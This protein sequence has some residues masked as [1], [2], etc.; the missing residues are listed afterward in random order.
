METRICKKCGEKKPLTNELW[1]KSK[2]NKGGL[3]LYCK[4]C[5]AVWDREYYEKHRELI[6]KRSAQW[7]LKNKDKKRICGKKTYQKIKNKLSIGGEVCIICNSPIKQRQIVSNSGK[8]CSQECYWESL[9]SLP[10]SICPVCLR[11]FKQHIDGGNAARF[12][13]RE[14]QREYFKKYGKKYGNN[15]QKNMKQSRAN[16]DKRYLRHEIAKQNKISTKEI[17]KDMVS[18]KE[19]I[20]VVHRERK[21]AFSMLSNTCIKCGKEFKRYGSAL[22]Y[23]SKSCAA[24]NMWEEREVSKWA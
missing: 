16:L 4:Q 6:I 23:C 13:S 12:C 8:Y 22:L 1:V 2:R 7:G 21:K 17:T 9:R 14:C 20:L 18:L 19:L 15:Y 24:K 11:V 5:K 10:N 3:S